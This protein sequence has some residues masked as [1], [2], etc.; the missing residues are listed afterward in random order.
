MAETLLAIILVTSSAKGSSL[1]FRWPPTPTPSARLARPRP[2]VDLSWSHT[3]NTF[4]A[5]HFPDVPSGST[6]DVLEGADEYEWRR[7]QTA[8][9]VD[10][11]GSRAHSE[12]GRSSPVKDGPYVDVADHHHVRQSQQHQS[13]ANENAYEELLGFSAEFLAGMLC[14]QRALCHQKFELVVDDVAFIGH[15]VCAETDARDDSG[16]QWRFKPEKLKA[17]VRGRG[18][19]NRAVQ[20]QSLTKDF[21]QDDVQDSAQ[22]GDADG[23][24]TVQTSSLQTFHLA[25]V[26]DLPDPSSSAAGNLTKYFDVIYEHI[27]FTVTAVLFQEQVLHNFVETECDALGVLKDECMAKRE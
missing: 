2:K 18:S 24:Q 16:G 14:P 19:R 3:E 4:R 26:I 12:S 17:G 5:A 15:P 1:V 9:V 27:A 21:D 6:G 20:D 23:S 7:P 10:D 22:E 25:L 8:Y 13:D 11:V